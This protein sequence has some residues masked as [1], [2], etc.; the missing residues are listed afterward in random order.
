M[1]IHSFVEIPGNHMKI[2][3][4]D[5][6]VLF[7]EG[8]VSLLESQS[9]MEV[10]GEAKTAEDGVI[11]CYE[12]NPDLV[13][14][15]ISSPNDENLSSMRKMRK[16][17][18]DLIVVVLAN[19]KSDELLFASLRS[20]ATGFLLKNSSFENVIAS[21]R[22]LERGEAAISREMTRSVIDEFVRMCS[23]Y[24][25]TEDE[26]INKLTPREQDVLRYISTGATNRE[27]ASGLYITESTVKIHV[28]N[29]L[30]KLSLRNRR[31]AASYAK[32]HSMGLSSE[33]MKVFRSVKTND[34]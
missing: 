4:V 9:D 28:S 23:D 7:R 18:A 24:A 13:L 19:R 26:E 5:S 11:L 33:E 20:G 12:L 1:E 25:G 16:Q 15:N 10:V 29:I 8:L 27:I 14:M 6:H 34:E 3:V 21:I 31:E 22:A 32:R 17:R 2:V 30:E